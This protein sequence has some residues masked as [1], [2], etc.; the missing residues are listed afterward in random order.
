M[1]GLEEIRI[2][3]LHRDLRLHHPLRPILRALPKALDRPHHFPVLAFL[4]LLAQEHFA[5]HLLQ[6][7][8]YPHSAELRVERYQLH[9]LRRRRLILKLLKV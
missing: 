5:Q 3:H 7:P 6:S 1:Q 9:H 4:N 2:V 8:H